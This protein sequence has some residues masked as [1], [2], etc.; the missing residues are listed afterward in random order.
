MGSFDLCLF[1]ALDSLNKALLEK[2][3][4]FNLKDMEIDTGNVVSLIISESKH[5]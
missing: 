4:G 5:A 2:P 3:L 1:E